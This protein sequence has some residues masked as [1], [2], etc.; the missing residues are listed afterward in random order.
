MTTSTM[1][2]FCLDCPNTLLDFPDMS[3]YDSEN[4]QKIIRELELECPTCHKKW[5]IYELLKDEK[6]K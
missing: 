6:P 4:R 1:K 3:L 2:L 5:T